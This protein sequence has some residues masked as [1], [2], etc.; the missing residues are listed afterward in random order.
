MAGRTNPTAGNPLT[1]KE[2]SISAPL[3][4][5]VIEQF[6]ENSLKPLLDEVNPM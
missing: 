2:E 1:G 3:K 5:A 6:P 4:I